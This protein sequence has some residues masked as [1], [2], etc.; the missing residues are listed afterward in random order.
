MTEKEIL[1][2]LSSFYRANVVDYEQL[3]STGTD[4]YFRSITA[5]RGPM[6]V[7][8]TLRRTAIFFDQAARY[9]RRIIGKFEYNLDGEQL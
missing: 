6:W 3:G 5:F 7:Y 1:A 8:H 4:I 9:V 2:T